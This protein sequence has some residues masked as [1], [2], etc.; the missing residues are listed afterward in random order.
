V[1][2]RRGVMRSLRDIEET[3]EAS[4]AVEA[5]YTVACAVRDEDADTDELALFFHPAG[6]DLAGACARCAAPSPPSSVCAPATWCRCHARPSAAPASRIDRDALLHRLRSGELGAEVA[7]ASHPSGGAGG[8]IEARVAAAV[9]ETLDCDAPGRDDNLFEIGADSVAVAHLAAVLAADF[10][11]RPPSPVD[12]YR[13]TTVGALA[14]WLSASTPSARERISPV[15]AQREPT[16]IAIIGAALRFPGAASPEELWR[17]LTGA[18]DSISFFTPDELVAAGVHPRWLAHPDYVPA[19]GALTGVEDFDAGFF[20]MSS[21]DAD[22]LDPQQ[23]LLLECAWEA[24]ERAGHASRESAPPHRRVLRHPRQR[25]PH[26]QPADRRHHRRHRGLAGR[27]ARSSH[28]QRPGLRGDADRVQ[29]RPAGPG[30]QRA[31]RLLDLAGRAAPRLQEPA[32]R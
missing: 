9:A 23:R 29:A 14:D 21:A 19:A 25:I 11:D 10:P 18:V 32:R 7:A 24:L 26:L 12:L 17:N 30:D 28:R 16:D 15:R 2:K 5:G 31:H 4:R 13:L 20:G 6:P 1:L 27:R 3:V 8:D 22:M